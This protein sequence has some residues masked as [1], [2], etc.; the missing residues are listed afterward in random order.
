VRA[1]QVCHESIVAARGRSLFHR[2]PAKTWRSFLDDEAGTTGAPAIHRGRYGW[3]SIISVGG[4]Q[5]GHSASRAIRSVPP[6]VP[7]LGSAGGSAPELYHV[8]D[9]E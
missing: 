9:G 1:G 4:I 6:Y 8:V 3:R 7:V 2:R 5:S